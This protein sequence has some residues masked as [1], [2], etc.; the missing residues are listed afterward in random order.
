[1]GLLILAS[2][3]WLALHIGLAGTGLRGLLARPLGDQGFRGLF[4]L[5]SIAVFAGL[6]YAF[7]HAP[8]T[9]LWV[10]P[11][12]LRWILVALML[13]ALFLLLGSLRTI[14]VNP[15]D[16]GTRREAARGILRITRHPMMCAFSLWALLHIIGTGEL[17]ALVFFGAF[18]VTAA[19]GMPSIDAKFARRDPLRWQRM[20]D[21]TS[22]LPGGAILAGRNRLVWGEIGWLLPLASLALWV[23]LLLLHRRFFGVAPAPLPWG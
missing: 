15:A 14:S 21:E 1:M 23:A 16:A 17:S 11:E 22:I 19:I 7:I 20:A 8:R 12:W 3:A 4:S 5:L 2:A 10:A 6:I 18:L 9:P 13:P